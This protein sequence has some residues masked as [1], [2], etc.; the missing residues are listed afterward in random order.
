MRKGIYLDPRTNKWY[1][2]T[3]I[4]VGNQYKTCTI[5]GFESKKEANDNF[6]YAIEKWKREHAIIGNSQFL[7]IIDDYL[8]YRSKLVRKESLRKDKTQFKYYSLIFECDSIDTIYKENR[9]KIIYNNILNNNDFSSQKKMRLV[10]AFRDFSKFCYLSKY[11]SQDTY[12]MVLMVFLP[13]KE[14]RQDKKTKRNIPKSHFEALISEINKVN[15][16]LFKLAIFVLYSC[17][18]RISELLGLIDSDV[19]LENRVIKVQRQ[20]QSNGEITTTLKTNNSY[21]EVPIN[22]LLF[23]ILQKNCKVRENNTRI[24]NYSHTSFKRKLKEYEEK[25]N[26]P[27]YSCHEFRHTCCYELAKK[28]ENMSDVVYCAKVMGHS[29]S[30]YLNTYCSHLDKSLDKKFFN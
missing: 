16:D 12:N 24:F 29:I 20:L 6:D 11:I 22:Q 14:D 27:L 15:D 7:S 17:G 18:L 23:E 8:S 9:L 13:I 26:I 2:A 25:A 4:K 28:C 5:R 19:D 1:I 3:K 21:R 30:V 10:L